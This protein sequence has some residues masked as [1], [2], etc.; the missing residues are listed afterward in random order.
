MTVLSLT[1]FHGILILLYSNNYRIHNI[2]AYG[3]DSV[4]GRIE[5]GIPQ[6]SL[7]L[8]LSCFLSNIDDISKD[9]LSDSFLF[10]DD[11]LLLEEVSSPTDSALKLNCGL[12][13][14]STR[15]NQWLVTM[16]AARTKSMII[17]T[18]EKS[19]SILSSIY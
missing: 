1:K 6:G 7:F 4:W 19:P 10:A 13:S 11:S 16:N 2:H 15:G 18:K 12:H 3:V 9:I 14:I 17:S 5:A 8:V